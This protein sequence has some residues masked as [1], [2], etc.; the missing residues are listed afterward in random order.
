MLF[1]WP[2]RSYHQVLYG[3]HSLQFDARKDVGIL[4][5]IFGIEPCPAK[6]TV[7]DIIVLDD[8]VGTN[9]AAKFIYYVLEH[10]QAVQ[11]EALRKLVKVVFLY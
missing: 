11:L 6:N 10:F 5:P 4:E 9:T 8:Q 2:K 3:H 1:F 7:A